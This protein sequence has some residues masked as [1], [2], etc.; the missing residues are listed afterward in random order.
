MDLIGFLHFTSE[1]TEGEKLKKDFFWR[2]LEK[3]GELYV[4][5][6]GLSFVT[7]KTGFILA[8]HARKLRTRGFILVCMRTHSFC[9][10]SQ[11]FEMT[12]GANKTQNYLNLSV[13]DLNLVCCSKIAV[14]DLNLVCWP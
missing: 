5:F 12:V 8:R 2:Y 10:S 14:G 3:F 4:V 9:W 6:K 7:N 11:S 13:E 1:K